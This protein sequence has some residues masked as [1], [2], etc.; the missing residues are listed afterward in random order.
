METASLFI[1]RVGVVLS[2]TASHVTVSDAEKL[3]VLR[4]GA[5]ILIK[6]KIYKSSRDVASLIKNWNDIMYSVFL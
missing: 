5:R 3:H 1:Q 2:G 6:G 4:V